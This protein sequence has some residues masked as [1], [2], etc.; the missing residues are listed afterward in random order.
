MGPVKRPLTFNFSQGLELKDD[1]KQ[2]PA[3][4]FLRLINTVFNK[5]GLLQKRNGF[6]QL[7]L[8]PID[9]NATYLTTFNGDL[10]AISNT[11][12]AFNPAN[13]NWVNKG[14]IQPLNLSTLPLIRSNTSQTQ[15]DIAI[16]TSGLICTV[17]TDQDPSNLSNSIYKYVVADAKTGQ[18]IIAPTIIPASSGGV[19]VGAPRVFYNSNN[20]IILFTNH[21]GSQFHL[22]FI[23]V[24]TANIGLVTAPEDISSSYAPSDRLSY[25][26]AVCNLR[27][28]VFFNSSSGGQAV[29]ACYIDSNLNVSSFVTFATST[30]T[31]MSVGT[32]GTD[33][34]ASFYDSVSMT[35][36][37]VAINQALQVLLNPTLIISSTVVDN[38]TN[39]IQNGSIYTYY[40]VE[41]FYGYDSTLPTNYI[42][43]ISVPIST[44]I[45]TAPYIEVRSLGL[46]SKVC[47]VN[48]VQYYLAAYQSDLQSTY[49]LINATDSVETMPIMVGKLAY[50]NGGGYLGTGLPNAIVSG[51]SISTPYLFKDLITSVNKDTN[52]PSGTQVDGIYS[53]TGIN[54]VT[55]TLGSSDFSTVEIA[56]TLELTGGFFW[57]YDGYVPVEQNFFVYPDNVE[58]TPINSGGAMSP[59]KYY[60]QVIYEWTDNQGNAHQSAPSV[61][62]L[63][64]MSSDNLAFIQPTPIT[65]TGAGAAG[66]SLLDASDLTGLE[67]GQIL[68]DTSNPS[69]LQANTAITSVF[70]NPFGV[71]LVGLSLPIAANISS[72]T[73]STDTICSVSLSIPT[74]R[75]TYKTSNPVKAV[76]YRWS[77]G[78][79]NYYQVT[80]IEMPLLNDMT[81]DYITF[82]DTL[83]DSEILGNSLIYTTGGVVE[84]INAP[85]SSIATL[86]QTR[87]FLVDAED[88]NL[89]WYSKQVIENTPVEMS[90]LFT[91]YVAPTIGASGPTGPITALGA[92]DDKLIIFKREALNYISGS[93]PDNTGSNNLFTDPIFITSVVGCTNQQ[94]II[95]TPTGLMFQSDKGIWLLDRDLGTSYIGSPVD[96]LVIGANVLSAV[97]VPGTNQVRFTMDTGITLMYDYFYGQ[98]SSFEN[99]PGISSCIYNGLH[100]FLDSFGRVFQETPG[101]YLD[102]TSPVLMQF[103]TGWLNL[104]GIQ[105]Y[106]RIYEFALNGNYLSPHLLNIL[107]AYDFE[108]PTQQSI[109]KPNNYTGVFGSDSL[110]GQTSPFGGP[111][112]LE[113]WRIFNDRQKCQVF[114]ITLEEV[115]DPSFGTVAGAGLTISGITCEIGV[116]SGY[117]PYK[118]SNSVG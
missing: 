24:S 36:Y 83:A 15:A 16:S 107:V 73:I 116:K 109:I 84:D 42:S 66:G 70:T 35:G 59:Q 2:I 5:G 9:T 92:M 27:L 32:D 79:Q 106:Q 78:Q 95:N 28:F 77:A 43:A 105:G 19:I 57:M 50:Q 41:N 48:D 18:N 33:I 87:L 49:F 98:W 114:Q 13:D 86:W 3:G 99:I 112:T 67:I 94:S 29:R 7:T 10:T 8:L 102:G 39:T 40:E 60:Y 81:V 47:I 51:N 117:R 93:G 52:V 34:A 55:F 71:H 20:F 31:I 118:G 97:L 101:L 23:A 82:T 69:S 22:Q 111:N 63:V 113:Q 64:D 37:S 6:E 12:S 38:L 14:S 89:V 1:P 115:F 80:S 103:T 90:D 96:A 45:P 74:L 65:F 11:I 68:T 100:T 104:A 108:N 91:L 4:K 75:L 26:A 72:D 56:S 62:T 88:P 30:A 61:P 85:A 44:G 17:Y 25:D 58:G 110:Y 54:Y 76:I 46:A 21:I 53:Q